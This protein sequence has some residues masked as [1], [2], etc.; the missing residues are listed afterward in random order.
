MWDDVWEL[1]VA[2][3]DVLDTVMGWIKRKKED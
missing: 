2:I 3:L 1:I